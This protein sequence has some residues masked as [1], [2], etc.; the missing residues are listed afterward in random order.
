M[1]SLRMPTLCNCR[2][3]A[4]YLPSYSA[5]KARRLSLPRRIDNSRPL[6][7]DRKSRI[8]FELEYQWV[9]VFSFGQ[10]QTCRE[11]GTQGFRFQETMSLETAGLPGG[12]AHKRFLVIS[13]VCIRHSVGHLI[14]GVRPSKLYAE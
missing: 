1:P 8:A 6:Q 2:T 10:G 9:S 12:A 5:G 3:F 14:H 11:A 4:I 13:I 7:A